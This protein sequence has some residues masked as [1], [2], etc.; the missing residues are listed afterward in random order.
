MEIREK[1]ENLIQESVP[2]ERIE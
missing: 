1:S 2:R